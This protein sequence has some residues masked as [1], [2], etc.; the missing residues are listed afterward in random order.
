MKRASLSTC[1]GTLLVFSFAGA[2][3]CTLGGCAV[4]A[5]ADAVITVTAVAVKATAEVAG[6]GVHAATSGIKALTKDKDEAAD[7]KK[8]ADVKAAPDPNK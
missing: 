2:F 1:A 7:G 4:I 6:A 3:A 5:V 8:S